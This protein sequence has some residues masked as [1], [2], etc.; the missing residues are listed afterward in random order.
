MKKKK[1]ENYQLLKHDLSKTPKLNS[2][3]RNV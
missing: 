2:I 1:K 3:F